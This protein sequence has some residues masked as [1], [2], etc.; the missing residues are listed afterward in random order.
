MGFKTNSLPFE[1][2]AKSLPIKYLGKHKDQLSLLEAMIF[3]QAGLIPEYPGDAYVIQLQQDYN[4]LKAKFKL[5]PIE[6]HLWK[7][8]RMRPANFPT[9]RLAQFAALIHQSSGLFSKIIEAKTMAEIE[10][11]FD[12][13]A[14]KYWDTHYTFNKDSEKKVK[15]L[16]KTAFNNIVINTIAPVL[17]FY[18]KAKGKEEYFE[19]AMD[20]L[21]EVNAENNNITRGWQALGLK[22]EHAF[23]SQALIQL[24]NVYCKSRG[25]LKCRIGNQVI[26]Y[27]L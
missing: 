1:M 12:I 19:I 13:K 26:K 15:I 25:C 2:V 10:V 21:S 5:K 9:I 20:L 3:G 22:M 16:G 11:L 6:S 27:N 7:F 8:M 18:A 17:F 4:H 23:D 14:S 24:K